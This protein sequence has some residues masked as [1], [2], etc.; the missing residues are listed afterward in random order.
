MFNFEDFE[1]YDTLLL[2]W[3]T[4]FSLEGTYFPV[5]WGRHKE[6]SLDANIEREIFSSG[7]LVFTSQ[8]FV[9]FSKM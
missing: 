1:E 2:G 8:E 6:D 5:N 3:L 9:F 4:S 7:S